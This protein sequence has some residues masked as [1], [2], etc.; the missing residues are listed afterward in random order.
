MEI[1]KGN[2]LRGFFLLFLFYLLYS[3]G[4]PS[5][6]IFLIG[7]IYLGFYL[8][9]DKLRKFIDS[10]LHTHISGFGKFHPWVKVAVVFIIFILFYF[11][12]KQVIYIGLSAVGVDLHEIVTKAFVGNYDS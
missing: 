3:S 2:I 6:L 12:L 4:V 5:E 1:K 7:L 8:F 9:R 11:A 10:L